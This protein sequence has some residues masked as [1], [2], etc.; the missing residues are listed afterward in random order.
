MSGL[1]KFYDK[2]VT[3]AVLF[4]FTVYVI[5]GYIPAGWASVSTSPSPKCYPPGTFDSYYGYCVTEPVDQFGKCPDKYLYDSFLHKCVAYP[6]CEGGYV[7]NTESKQCEPIEAED[8][9]GE[10]VSLSGMWCGNDKNHDGE[11]SEDE[12]AECIPVDGGYLCPLDAVECD[13]QEKVADCPGGYTYNSATGKCEYSPAIGVCQSTQVQTEYYQCPTTGNIYY[14][15]RICN[16]HCLQ[17]ATCNR[18]FVCPSGFS[19]NPSTGKCETGVTYSCPSGSFYDSN[20]GLCVTQATPVCRGYVYW[21]YW[22]DDEGVWRKSNLNA[23]PESWSNWVHYLTKTD[24]FYFN[25]QCVITKRHRGCFPLPVY[26]RG[27]SKDH[28]SNDGR[29]GEAYLYNT[30]YN[31]CP[32]GFVYN[33]SLGKCTASPN[34]S[35]PSGSTYNSSTGKCEKSPTVTYTCP[36]GDYPC[37]GS[38]PTC[39]K[40][41]TCVTHSKNITKW[42]CSLD[43]KQYDT[44]EQCTS[45]CYEACPSGGVYNLSTQKCEI[46]PSG[47][48]CPEGTIEIENGECVGCP[49]E[50][51]TCVNNDGV[52]MCSPYT[53]SGIQNAE[54]G[55]EPPS[56]YEDDTG[57][58]EEGECVGTIFIFNGK[59]MRCRPPGLQVGFH[60]CCD[61]V[62]GKLYD[63]TGSTGMMLGDAI[64]AVYVCLDLVKKAQFLS[65]VKAVELVSANE[66]NLLNEYGE[67][68]GVAKGTEAEVWTDLVKNRGVA[69]EVG[70]NV[71]QLGDFSETYPQYVDSYLDHY[72]PKLAAQIV[73]MALTKAIDDPVLS[74]AVDLVAQSILYTMNLASGWGIALAALN[75]GMSL[76]MGSCDKQDILTSTYKE[77][78]YCHYV[79]KKC[80]KKLPLVGCVQKAKVYCCFNSKLARIIHEQGRP[81]LS[82]FGPSGGWGSAKR[83]NCRGFTPEE[84]QSIDF[85]KIDF[86]EYVA[87]IQRNIRRNVEPQMKEIFQKSVQSF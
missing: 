19:Y 49:Y 46:A 36:L 57:Y 33:K 87:D 76:F 25:S 2:T 42:Q 63:S 11:L 66:V 75:L 51:S 85:G 28:C 60:N 53:C 47:F 22:W 8:V 29:R 59:K 84:F 30:S 65:S 40:G 14:N 86:S 1:R 23:S 16:N 61:E 69:T 41:E 6:Y 38:P 77:S 62:Q 34:L 68:I 80:I 13:I 52:W 64:K 58:N 35:C 55:D 15:L 45:S 7:Y 70:D 5:F 4:F 44:Q 18:Q 12:I 17:V 67:T 82:S 9:G 56:G 32:P 21:H 83:P 81:Q 72:A 26:P 48:E 43:G 24:R 78:G 54:G 73:T 20:L 10:P 74:A 37:S 31:T 27:H 3:L 79:G 39:Q 71:Y 50:N